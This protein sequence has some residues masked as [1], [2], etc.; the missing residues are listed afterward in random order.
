[1][2]K[3]QSLIIG[4]LAIILLLFFGAQ[5]LEKS[6]GMAG[7]KVLNIYNWGDYIDSDLLKQFEKHYKINRFELNFDNVD[8]SNEISKEFQAVHNETYPRK[9]VLSFNK[10]KNLLKIYVDMIKMNNKTY[11]DSLTTFRES[12]AKLESI[13]EFPKVVE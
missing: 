2:K 3:L 8:I 13:I 12:V 1:M 10:N 6:S 4:I 5:Q 7:A 11:E 9:K